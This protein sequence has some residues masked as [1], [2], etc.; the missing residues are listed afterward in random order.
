M[1]KVNDPAEH[2]RFWTDAMQFERVGDGRYRCGDS[3]VVIAERGRV[4]RSDDWRGPGYRYT[5]GGV[6]KRFKDFVIEYFPTTYSPHAE[7]L[8]KLRCRLLHN[9][10][11]AYFT[12]AHAAPAEHLKQS[13]IGDTI[14]SDDV[15]FADLKEAAHKFFDEVQK[16]T[17]RQT[18]MNARLLNVEEGGAIYYE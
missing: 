1:L 6:G 17:S 2:D 8:Y 11:P 7:N 10:S 18:V 9:F 12:L 13:Q 4:E 14:L 3:L 15:F 5:T 16:D